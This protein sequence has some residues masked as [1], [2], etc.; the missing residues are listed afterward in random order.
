MWFTL[1]IVQMIVRPTTRFIC[2][3]G[4]PPAVRASGG[5]DGK[6]QLLAEHCVFC[7]RVCIH[8]KLANGDVSLVA[9]C[10]Y[11]FVVNLVGAAV[12]S[13]PGQRP[14]ED[15]TSP[16]AVRAWKFVFGALYSHGPELCEVGAAIHHLALQT[17]RQK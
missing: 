17:T 5:R 16:H 1:V 9:A 3:S 7:C 14:A 12:R 10:C 13:Q 2:W 8:S 6:Q 11:I 15:P 4:S